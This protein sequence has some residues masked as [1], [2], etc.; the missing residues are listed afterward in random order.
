MKSSFWLLGFSLF[1]TFC[2]CI[3][4]LRFYEKP[5]FGDVE[6]RFP[7]LTSHGFQLHSWYVLLKQEREIHQY[8][9]NPDLVQ[10]LIKRQGAPLLYVQL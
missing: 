7:V 4:I 1:V 5:F 9:A 3:E 2:S 8:F 6:L 10:N